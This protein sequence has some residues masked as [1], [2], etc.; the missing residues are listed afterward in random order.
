M[1]TLKDTFEEVIRFESGPNLDENFLMRS[2]IS[3][4]L[5]SLGVKMEIDYGG[6]LIATRGTLTDGEY[7]PGICC[8]IDTV[9]PIQY[10]GKR[11]YKVFNYIDKDQRNCYTAS[12]GIG[13]DDKCGIAIALVLLSWFPK[14]KVFFFVGEES[15]CIGSDAVL[16]D[17][18]DDVGYL[19]EPDRRGNNDL[20]YRYVG[21]DTMDKKFLKIAEK[22]SKPFGYKKTSGST[23]DVFHLQS[24]GVHLSAMNLSVGYYQPHTEGEYII[25]EDF[26][27][28]YKVV[29]NILQRAGY[30]RYPFTRPE[31]KYTPGEYKSRGAYPFQG[32]GNYR[33]YSYPAG[34]STYNNAYGWDENGDFDADED[35]P[36]A[37]KEEIS[38]KSIAESDSM[39]VVEVDDITM[40]DIEN[41]TYFGYIGNHFIPLDTVTE[42]VQSQHNSDEI[43]AY[44]VTEAAEN[45][46][47]PFDIALQ[48]YTEE[49][50][51]W[52]ARKKQMSLDKY[53]NLLEDSTTG[54]TGTTGVPGKNG[55]QKV[56]NV[57]KL[58]DR[59]HPLLRIPEEE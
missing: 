8:H 16:L 26:E 40:D 44:L 32:Y 20:I 12:T 49:I 7:Y 10:S 1:K 3:Y 55:K 34:Y 23:T 59:A 6:N 46:W 5:G 11:D 51:I 17:H 28:S 48:T 14:L 29:K 2:Y 42:W 57:I 58:P 21:E 4:V 18:F 38:Q 9:H 31:K 25:Y 37:A 47:N 24:R 52:L 19:I 36:K 33:G 41:T 39:E 54:T 22:A 50:V 15:G 45:E 35:T 56:G 27:R 43:L 53:G 30:E 13:G